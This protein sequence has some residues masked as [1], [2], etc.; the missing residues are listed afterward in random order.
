MKYSLLACSTVLISAISM[1]MAGILPGPAILKTHHYMCSQNA[2]CAAPLYCRLSTV[3]SE[4]GT[5]GAG[6]F[7][8]CEV[9]T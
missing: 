4:Q 7:G 2:V 9:P 3:N 8:T 1:V 6:P 5:V